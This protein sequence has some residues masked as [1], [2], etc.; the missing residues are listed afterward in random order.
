MPRLLPLAASVAALLV[1]FGAQAAG[2][3]AILDAQIVGKP[4]RGACNR[5]A[6]TYG[7]VGDA[8]IAVPT[9][10]AIITFPQGNAFT[11]RAERSFAIA[12]S[13]APRRTV[14]A[15]I[16]KVSIRA[17][18][19]TTVQVVADPTNA[20][21]EPLQTQ[22]N[23]LRTFNVDVAADCAGTASTGTKPSTACDLSLSFTA[24]AGSTVAAGSAVSYRVQARN[25]GTAACPNL[26]VQLHRYSGSSA[27]G[28]GSAVG[29]TSGSIRAV[30]ALAAG[31][32]HDLEWVDNVAAGTFT[33]QAKPMG[34]WNDG[35]NGNHRPAKTVL[36][37]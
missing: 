19:S 27:G 21:G 4:L 26:N 23:N 8:T 12:G 32:T 30:P 22:G 2:D 1:S 18:G 36:A 35:N 24:P 6:V 28:Y 10:G 16:D 15:T 31:A 13:L 7:N 25:Q 9:K 3:L 33:Y 29:G 5:V 37:N 14:T 20:A 17:L 11:N 34:T